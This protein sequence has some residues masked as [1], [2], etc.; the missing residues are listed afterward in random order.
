MTDQERYFTAVHEAAHAICHLLFKLPM[1]GA[2]I[3]PE[4]GTLGRVI[5]KQPWEPGIRTHLIL[6]WEPHVRQR[7]H[8]RIIS[9]L[10][11][12]AAE[13]LAKAKAGVFHTGYLFDTPDCK[14]AHEIA[15]ILSDRQRRRGSARLAES[16]P[17]QS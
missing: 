10:A 7:N 16:P 5:P 13:E 4:R 1:G 6:G 9:L 3:V 15:D 2:S 8:D 14:N 17:R 11:G 12:D